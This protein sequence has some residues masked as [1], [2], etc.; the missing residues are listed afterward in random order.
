MNVSA[1]PVHTLS[2]NFRAPMGTCQEKPSVEFLK[3]APMGLVKSL[4]FFFVLSLV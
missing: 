2:G 4:A 1:T 3:S